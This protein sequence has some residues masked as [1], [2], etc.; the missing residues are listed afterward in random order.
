MD[1]GGTGGRYGGA[2]AT[3]RYGAVRPCYARGGMPRAV[4]ARYGAVR[5]GTAGSRHGL[6]RLWVL[7]RLCMG[8]RA[9][10]GTS[11]T[12]GTDGTEYGPGGACKF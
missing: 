3:D 4:Y 1:T 9:V 11:G 5:G 2:G 6:V 7:R 12:G 8:G 10:R